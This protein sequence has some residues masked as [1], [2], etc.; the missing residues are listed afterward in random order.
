MHSYICIVSGQDTG[1]LKT[2]GT[3]KK[4][5]GTP[6]TPEALKKQM[7]HH[8]YLIII[9]IFGLFS[10]KYGVNEKTT[11][12]AYINNTCLQKNAWDSIKSIY[13]TSMIGDTVFLEALSG[14]KQVSFPVSLIYFNEEPREL[15]GVE[16]SSIRYV[17]NPLISPQIL[18][19]L[20][21]ELKEAEKKRIRTRVQKILMNYQCEEGRKEA[22]ILMKD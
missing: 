22:E 20:S 13:S 15:I 4:T 11:H 21:P 7:R 8:R 2:V 3:G 1:G 9:V 6:L 16:Y 14:F 10:C 5:Y 18:D 19:G 12:I 17:F